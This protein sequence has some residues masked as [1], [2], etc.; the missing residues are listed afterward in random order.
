MTG[1][2]PRTSAL[3]LIE[4]VVDPGSWLR[5]DEPVDITTDDP[6]YR[7]DLERARERTGLD[8]SVI[9]GEGRIE[10]RRVAIVA[11]EFRFLAGSIGVAS[12]ERLV[13]AVER[14]TA[15]RLPLLAAPASGGTRMQEG[16]VAFLQ[17]VKVAAAITDHKAAG[18]PYLV[19]LRHPTTGGVLAS[20]GSLGHVTAA[21]PGALIGFLG[22]RVHEALYG[23]EFPP[24]V[25]VAENLMAHGLVDAVLP[26]ERLS[27]VAARVLRVL[28]GDAAAVA[29]GAVPGGAVAAGAVP[30]AGP[31][32]PAAGGEQET[33]AGRPAEEG[34]QAGRAAESEATPVASPGVADG[35]GPYGSDAAAAARAGAEGPGPTAAVGAGG[36][37]EG[38]GAAPASAG[39]GELP[40]ASGRGAGAGG[41]EGDRGGADMA[42]AAAD[43]GGEAGTAGDR[44]GAGA[45]PGRGGP[46]AEES[47]RRSRRGD[48]PGVRDLLRAAAEDVSP[49]SGTGAGE[50]DPGLLLALA[51][52]GGTPCVVLGH[53]RAA[54]H[55]DAAADGPGGGQPLGPAGLRTARRGMRIAAELGLPLLTVV[56]TAGA[57]LSREAE[58][59]GLAGE[60]ARCLA[61][62]VTL[63]AP[64]LCLLLGQGA[65]GAALAL[66]PADRVLAARHAWLSPL[67]PEGASAI[68]YRTTERAYEIAGRQGVRSADLLAHGIVDRIVEEGAEDAGA[69]AGAGAGAE[70]AA[71]D[72]F[73]ARLGDT[74]GAELAALRAQ[75]QG[76]RLAARRA[77]HRRIGLSR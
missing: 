23:E 50:H 76:E 40:M 26:P 4:T 14:A 70:R 3:Q 32:G 55:E 29:N 24:G 58:E 20:W 28:C 7:A 42:A 43:G 77:R 35:Y 39:R 5:W 12:G 57:A 66:L 2:N 10:G 22:P 72:S 74:L 36:G 61:D 27:E 33:A 1:T 64:T 15:E 30:A 46:G 71:Y 13:R 56:D 73:L 25:Q 49:L 34:D 31:S 21:E 51:R 67:P 17:M 68:L 62:M 48:R 52:V 8:E 53:D 6:D 59:G 65:G 19:H 37:P 45:A 60:I 16:T 75:D 41:G 63:P 54:R 38:R 11:C 44:G 9:T 69:G 18:L 47:I